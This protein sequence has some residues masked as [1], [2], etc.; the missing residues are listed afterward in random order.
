MFETIDKKIIPEKLDVFLKMNLLWSM[1]RNINCMLPDVLDS[2]T[3]KI[4]APLAKDM[5]TMMRTGK[6]YQMISFLPNLAWSCRALHITDESL[7]KR[8]D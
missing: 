8:I 1:G 7:W 4:V 5:E 6:E 2:L 3:S